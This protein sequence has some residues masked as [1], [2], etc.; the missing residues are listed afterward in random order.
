M[1]PDGAVLMLIVVL[2]YPS[3]SS[4]SVKVCCCLAQMA[5]A[6]RWIVQ[7]VI[8]GRYK[9]GVNR[10]LRD[11]RSIAAAQGHAS[12]VRSSSNQCVRLSR[13]KSIRLVF[14]L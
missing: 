8:M 10:T 11:D 7:A 13:C 5:R 6:Q 12:R 14:L 1:L 2:I 9:H 3:V 4:A